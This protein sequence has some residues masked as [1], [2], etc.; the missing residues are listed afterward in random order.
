MYFLNERSWLVW[1]VLM[2]VLDTKDFV[3][4]SYLQFKPDLSELIFIKSTQPT[5]KTSQLCL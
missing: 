3:E 5:N 4:R 1:E 2:A